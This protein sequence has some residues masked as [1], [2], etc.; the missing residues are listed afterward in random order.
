[1]IEPV[2]RKPGF[3][4]IQFGIARAENME[5]PKINIVLEEFMSVDLTRKHISFSLKQLFG[6][7]RSNSSSCWGFFFC[8]FTCRLEIPVAVMTPNMTINIPPTT[9]S[10]MVVSTALI[11]PKTPIKIMKTPLRRI[12]LLLPTCQAE[13]WFF[14]FCWMDSELLFC[15]FSIINVFA[16]MLLCLLSILPPC[17]ICPSPPPSPPA[18]SRRIPPAWPWLCS[19]FLPVTS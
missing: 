12:T 10:G 5:K 1:M 13:M 8:V 2:W 19:R 11:L 16:C 17:P 14:L 15:I 18:I 9:G 6:R 3:F 4:T 7:K